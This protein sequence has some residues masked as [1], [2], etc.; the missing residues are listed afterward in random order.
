[1]RDTSSS[2]QIGSATKGEQYKEEV[3]KERVGNMSNLGLSQGGIEIV[4]LT[5]VALLTASPTRWRET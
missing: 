3:S 1:M 5:T 2:A 4:M